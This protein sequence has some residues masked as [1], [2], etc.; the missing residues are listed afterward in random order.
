MAILESAGADIPSRR[1]HTDPFT[2]RQFP[3]SAISRSP[4]SFSTAIRADIG[5]SEAY[6][7]ALRRGEIGLQ[8]PM[9]AN[10][11]GADFITAVVRPDGSIEIVVTD[12]KTSE[13]GKFPTPK[14]HLP[15]TWQ[16]EVQHAIGP[17]RLN[18][19]DQVLEGQIRAAFQQGRIRLRQL[20]ANY[21]PSGQGVIT[22][23]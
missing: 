13:Q 23:W 2:G 3:V 12:V 19:H 14:A 16:T 17:T 5:E 10:V 4:R 8:R 1:M 18:L 6:K 7:Q 21:S 15:G 11:A 9:G 20:R 22:G